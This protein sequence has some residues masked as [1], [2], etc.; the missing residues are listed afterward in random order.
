[1]D[2]P[3]E[4]AVYD[5]VRGLGYEVVPQVGS[6]GFFIDLAVRD[7]RQ[8]GRYLL[9]IECDGASYHSS[10]NARDRDRLRQ[11]V[12]EDRGWK[13]HRIWST[14]WFRNPSQE[15]QRIH[16]H[17]EKE[18]SR[19]ETHSHQNPVSKPEPQIN[20]IKGITDTPATELY[21]TTVL[22]PKN[23]SRFS[24]FSQIPAYE[25][26]VAIKKILE[27]ESPVAIKAITNRL[28]NAAGL[29][30]AGSRIQNRVTL[31]LQEI[32][33]RDGI[34]IQGDFATLPTVGIKVRNRR[35][36][37]SGE[38]CLDF[39]APQEIQKG[40]L[41]VTDESLSIS[42]SDC[43][44]EVSSRLGFQRVTAQMNHIFQQQLD[45]LVTT[46]KICFA[47]GRLSLTKKQPES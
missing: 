26:H 12:L 44:S 1:M 7:P 33:S 25:I 35:D 30:R 4:T 17:I 41:D 14:D 10:V 24:D 9:A 34:L 27:T 8:P 39:V 32:A 13:F 36:V 47:D 3:F 5:A 6:Q 16:D 31:L 29:S 2:S 18:L 46:G 22:P 42:P 38:K 19:S 28:T 20:R 21:Q 45:A 40:I 15:I 37:P 23:W 43:F 11:A